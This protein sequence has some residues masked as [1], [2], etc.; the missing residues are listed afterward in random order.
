MRQFLKRSRRRSSSSTQHSMMSNLL[1]V[2]QIS[3]GVKRIDNDTAGSKQEKCD[4]IS[5]DMKSLVKIC[6]TKDFVEKNTRP[7]KAVGATKCSQNS[8]TRRAGV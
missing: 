8:A 5:N 1:G 2:K 3:I 4:E 6:W 7:A